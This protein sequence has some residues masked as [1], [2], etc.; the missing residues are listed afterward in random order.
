L[1]KKNLS[2]KVEFIYKRIQIENRKTIH[3]DRLVSKDNAKK[4]YLK[5]KREN[6]IIINLYTNGLHKIEKM[7]IEKTD[8]REKIRN[9]SNF[10]K[11]IS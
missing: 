2:V 11:L 7:L 9:Q 8:K 6:I 10:N 1:V 3:T 4:I 5:R